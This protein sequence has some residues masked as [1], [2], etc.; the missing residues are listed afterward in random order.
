MSEDTMAEKPCAAG[1]ASDKRRRIGACARC[2]TQAR[3][4]AKG[5]CRPCYDHER[6]AG[7]PAC[8]VCNSEKLSPVARAVVRAAIA[9][10][11]RTGKNPALDELQKYMRG[12]TRGQV[13]SGAFEALRCG[14]VEYGLAPVLKNRV[15]KAAKRIQAEHEITPILRETPRETCSKTDDIPGTSTM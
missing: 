10:R 8:R 14:A 5:M 11:K 12:F 1:A 3:I 7:D 2:G 15:G 6:C 13:V 4:V 9:L